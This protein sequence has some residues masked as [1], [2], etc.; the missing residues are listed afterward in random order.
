MSQPEAKAMGA[1]ALFGEKYGDQVRV[2]SVG[3][4]AHELCGGTHVE[5]TQQLGT[6]IL[7]NESSVAAGVRRVEA[8]AGQAALDY[9][10]AQHQT[11]T[12]VTA[13]A[14]NSDPTAVI[15]DLRAEV[16]ELQKKLEELN[17]LKREPQS[18]IDRWGRGHCGLSS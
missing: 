15:R 14:K 10:L 18:G 16:S 5:N 4:W 6:F 2:V 13:E 11:L 9:L 7:L 1:M 17:G 8:L 12:E 3:E